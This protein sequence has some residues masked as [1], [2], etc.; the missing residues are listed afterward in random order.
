[1]ASRYSRIDGYSTLVRDLQSNAVLN[2]D[3]VAVKRHEK[4][5][6]DLQKEEAR[7]KEI[8]I[9]KRDIFEIKTL[10]RELISSKSL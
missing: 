7:E 2:T 9:L 1:M 8:N 6:M 3:P 4:R 5:I 10:I